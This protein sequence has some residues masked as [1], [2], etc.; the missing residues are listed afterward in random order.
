[1]QFR[2]RSANPLGGDFRPVDVFLAIRYGDIFKYYVNLLFLRWN[3][4]VSTVSHHHLHLNL[5]IKYTKAITK[6]LRSTHL[7]CFKVIFSVSSVAWI[8]LF[9]DDQF[10]IMTFLDS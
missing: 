9:L 4:T 1:M 8:I 6:S 5:L 2:R 10:S 7:H 3:R